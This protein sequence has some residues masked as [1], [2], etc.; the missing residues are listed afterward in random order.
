MGNFS[1]PVI[2]PAIQEIYAEIRRLYP[3]GSSSV[4]LDVKRVATWVDMYASANNIPIDNVTKKDAKAVVNHAEK[5]L[6]MDGKS[7]RYVPE[8]TEDISSFSFYSG[9]ATGSDT[10]WKKAIEGRGGKVRDYIVK[11]YDTLPKEEKDKIEKEYQ[12]VV[13]AIKRKP[14]S[15]I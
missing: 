9:G 15:A 10:E 5:C 2:T 4:N 14:L 13:A 3:E 11:D 6:N 1:C 8:R 12:E 7:F